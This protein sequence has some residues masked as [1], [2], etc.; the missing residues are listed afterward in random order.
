M[1]FLF[2]VDTSASMNQTSP[3]GMSFLDVA[4]SAIEK[5]IMKRQ[6]DPRFRSTDRYLLVTCEEGLSAIKVII[7]AIIV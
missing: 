1:I 2:V 5:F 3:N 6:N 4:K 7:I